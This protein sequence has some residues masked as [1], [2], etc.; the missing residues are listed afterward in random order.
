[1]RIALCLEQT[2]GHRTHTRNLIEAARTR[3]VDVEVV[4]VECAE[5]G[6]LSMP[7]AVRAS[8]NA[9]RQLRKR[10]PV[11][12]A[13][14]HT[15]SVG[16]L[17]Q[18]ATGG[19]PYVISLDATP[20]QIDSMGS[21]YNHWRS[22]RGIEWGKATVYR[23]VLRGAAGIVAWSDWV[24]ASLVE[25]YGVDP[26]RVCVVPPGAGPE[27]FS[28][29]PHAAEA[30]PN[31]LFVGGD[32]YRKG[33]DVLLKVFEQL[34]G[35]A[36]LTI[37]TTDPLGPQPPGV[38]VVNNA[39]PGSRTL[40]ECYERAD[41]F[42][43]PTRADAAAIAVSEAMAAGLGVVTTNV[44]SVGEA[45]QSE[46][47]GLIVRPGSESEFFVALDRLISDRALL[48]RLRDGGRQRAREHLDARINAERLLGF[49]ETVA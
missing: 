23:R 6:R 34:A 47:S 33:G 35:R 39:T 15:Q 29:E 49:L 21:Y 38:T 3:P 40:I 36:T 42:C 18:R 48:R 45:V 12:V 7:W 44:G 46:Q 2:L 26:G 20:T 30:V 28:I 16:L 27:F 41:I 17:A 43:L 24:R 13:L 9:C 19:R 31:I 8:V 37:V 14:F 25:E 1:M 11:D 22:R 32:F 10:M 4:L 5:P